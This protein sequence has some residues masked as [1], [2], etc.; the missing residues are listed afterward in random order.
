MLSNVR[1][2]KI[3]L[4]S[5]KWEVAKSGML[6][7]CLS[8]FGSWLLVESRISSYML[9][10]YVTTELQPQA[11]KCFFVTFLFWKKKRLQKVAQKVL[12]VCI[13][14]PLSF[15]ESIFCHYC[16][17]SELG[18]RHWCSPQTGLRVHWSFP[19]ICSTSARQ[20]VDLSGVIELQILVWS[21][22]K[23]LIRKWK[24]GPRGTA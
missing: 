15:P 23:N 12:G 14:S 8:W 24:K 6:F 9:S 10:M 1:K 16:T 3:K 4:E 19:N 21:S 2:S 5:V 20:R 17:E 18:N 13:D 11:L 22:Y 7:R